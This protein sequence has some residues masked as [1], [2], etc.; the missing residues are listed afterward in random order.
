MLDFFAFPR[1]ATKGFYAFVDE[2]AKGGF[3]KANYIKGQITGPVT[4]G[5]QLNDQYLKAAYYDALLRDIIV[6][7]IALQ[8]CWQ[9]KILSQYEVPVIIFIDEPGLSAYGQSSYITL[10]KEEITGELNTIIDSLHM[11]GAHAGIHICAGTDW[12]MILESKVDILNF[13]AF[14][15]FTSLSLY[16]DELIHFMQRDGILAWGLVPTSDKIFNLT[17]NKLIK[18][19]NQHLDVLVKKSLIIENLLSQV[20]ITPSCGIG[21]V[22]IDTGEKVYQLTRNVSM[23]LRNKHIY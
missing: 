3:P 8:A 17:A 1:K 9:A 2:L 7:T 14:E 20:I 22:A 4:L 19:F 18:S 13:D 10:K 12:S 6:K 21:S 5:L 16:I 11:A 15:Y 23:Q